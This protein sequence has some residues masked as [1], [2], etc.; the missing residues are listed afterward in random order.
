MKLFELLAVLSSAFAAAADH[1]SRPRAVTGMLQTGAGTKT[2]MK[3][4]I[5]PVTEKETE[6]AFEEALHD[7]EP[8]LGRMEKRIGLN[9]ISSHVKHL[10]NS[11][12]PS[13]QL[14][15]F[16][17]T[18]PVGSS[19]DGSDDPVSDFEKDVTS[20]V[21]GLGRGANGTT[22]GASPSA[23]P[24]EP[25]MA[26]A[27]AKIKDLIESQL[28]P[29]VNE[30]H[31]AD[32]DELNQIYG[33][34]E[35][36]FTSRNTALQAALPQQKLYNDTSVTHHTCRSGESGLYEETVANHDAWGEKKK[37]KD[38][39]C[40]AYAT[41]AAQVG[42][43]QAN[44]EI[45]TYSGG[46][47]TETYVKRISVTICGDP[48]TKG[49]EVG[50]GGHG[51]NGLLDKLL[52]A[53]HACQASTEEFNRQTVTC[54]R[55]DDQWHKK[56]KQCDSLQDT[57]DGGA[58][59]YAIEKKDACEAFEGCYKAKKESY[60][61][62][63]VTVRKEE[64]DRKAEW[65]GLMRMHC[66]IEAFLDWKVTDDEI[67]HCR[68]KPSPTDHLSIAY[69][70]LEEQD[71]CTT[72]AKYPSNPA[73]KL[74][75]FTNLPT[76][77]K[78]KLDSNEC[79]GVA[80]ISTEP[81]AGSPEGCKCERIVLNGP[82]SPGPLVKCT[83]CS[84]VQRSEDPNSC[85]DGTK[86]FA[87]RTRD[88]WQTFLASATP[89]RDP[90]FIV[91]VT[92]P[93]SGCAGCN[94]HAMNSKTEQQESWVTQDG[95]PWWL[96]ST[97]YAG[98]DLEGQSLT[99]D[100]EAGCFLGFE[101]NPENADSITFSDRK[102]D[103][104]SKSYYC[105]LWSLDPTPKEGSPDGCT[106]RKV[107]F[108][109]GHYSARELIKCTGCLDVYRSNDKNSC[110]HG[111]KLWS[112]K[113][114]GDWKVF[115]A[116]ATREAVANPN[117]I[118]DVTRPQNG[119]G[120]CSGSAMNSFT[121]EQ[122]TWQ[123]A[124]GSPWWL[125]SDKELSFTLEEGGEGD[126]E[127]NCYLDLWQPPANENSVLFRA[128]KCTSHSDSYYCQTAN[129][130]RSFTAKEASTT[131]APFSAVR[132][133]FSTTPKVG[134]PQNC[135]CE[136][137]V[138]NGDYSAG[139][140]LKCTACLEVSKST[141]KNSCPENTRIFSP[142]SRADWKVLFAS[143]L[144]PLRAPNW[145]VDVTKTENGCEGCT[146]HPMNSAATGQA[147][148]KTTD[149]SPWWLRSSMGY[150]QPSNDYIANCYLDLFPEG[151]NYTSGTNGT[152]D[153]TNREDDIQFQD[154]YCKPT[155]SYYCQPVAT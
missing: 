99:G 104:H 14:K 89:L 136:E 46:E 50:N 16:G 83:G 133:H 29:Q 132:P 87:P 39:N 41:M 18:V 145:I 31:K 130:E 102:C 86:L 73:Y 48:L 21:L 149:G 40:K 107:E 56:K 122:A 151:Y 28:L 126:Y 98:P 140:L 57:M 72:P 116:S 103:Y 127:A 15:K 38:L 84:R 114:R 3:L 105:Q 33:E 142:Q 30:S 43:E 36:C 153:N 1:S 78:G 124:D 11:L 129:A 71:E 82:F 120:G 37:L 45:V 13:N 92:R 134:S 110:P 62:V 20:L 54:K 4:Q 70:N 9:A 125:R 128:N 42:N 49:E 106:C 90:N 113:S 55:L 152:V 68:S 26:G 135:T 81:K 118:V 137:V 44:K 101:T 65:R 7:E 146:D 155:A 10:A 35:A 27:V 58:C 79:T 63:E 115:I 108:V 85:P 2:A 34:H 147:P 100:Y 131:E 69:P 74:A 25:P 19:S 95:A 67:Q 139:A 117:F 154:G 53:K 119:C 22:D 64:I 111:T 59:N 109:G 23:S 150:D 112:P 5:D 77:A 60:E 66:L 88:D 148:W 80:E 144:E 93:Q 52:N 24:T 8:G 47:A 12:G 143:G 61:D 32:Q 138:L 75:E 121:A 141:D 76:F 91:D 17:K 51:P 96:R 6:E 123:T 94:E 97:K